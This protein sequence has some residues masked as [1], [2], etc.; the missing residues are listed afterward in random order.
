MDEEDAEDPDGGF[1]G[2][3]AG[4]DSARA[5]ALAKSDT[6]LTTFLRW[7]AKKNESDA[8]RAPGVPPPSTAPGH[9][10][11]TVLAS[12]YF[13]LI[14][15][16]H[17]HAE[18]LD[19]SSALAR[20][21]P[22]TFWDSLGRASDAP[23]FGGGQSYADKTYPRERDAEALRVEPYKRVARPLTDASLGFK[24]P[25][26]E[27]G[28]GASSS[29]SSSSFPSS[30]ALLGRDRVADSLG[31]CG[32]DPGSFPADGAAASA[33]LPLP[34]LW[35]AAQLLYHLG[36]S[37]HFKAAAY[38][39]QTQIQA[40]QQLEA[41]SSRL[42]KAEQ[43]A[44]DVA[45]STRAT[46]KSAVDEF[47]TRTTEALEERMNH[48]RDNDDEGEGG[49]GSDEASSA[50]AR[51]ARSA[52]EAEAARD[53]I[54]EANARLATASAEMRASTTP[55]NELLV[56]LRAARATLRDD[57]VE[58]ARLCWWQRA[59]LHR[60][61]Q[62]AG[63]FAVVAYGAALLLA[64]MDR[65]GKG[66]RKR[67]PGAEEKDPEEKDA[68]GDDARGDEA[69]SQE[70]ACSQ[71]EAR[72]EEDV[73]SEEEDDSDHSSDDS[74][75]P[76][77]NRGALLP[78]VSAYHLESLMDAFHALRRGDPPLSP[79]APEHLPGVHGVVTLLARHFADDRVANP[80]VRDAMLQSVSVLLQYPEYVAVFERNEEATRTMVP[81]LLRAF[82]SRF[83]IP[84]GNILLRLCKGAGFG[85][86][87]AADPIKAAADAAC[88][89][90]TGGAGVV[91]A[92]NSREARERGSKRRSAIGASPLF[93]RRIVDAC[94]SDP[95]LLAEFLDRLFNTLNWTITEL[96]VT[97]KEMLETRDR[98]RPHDARQLRRKCTV[99]FELSVTLERVLECFA[100][101]L[102]GAFL[103][104]D[105]SL[106]LGRLTESLVFVLGHTTVGPDATLFDRALT[107]RL[108]PV[109]KV[110]R[111]PILAPVAG[112]LLALDAAEARA[113]E[114]ALERDEESEGRPRTDDAL[115][116]DASDAS[117]SPMRRGPFRDSIASSLANSSCDVA[118]LEYLRD[119]PWWEH[120]SG[121]NE[122][123]A[124]LGDFA[125][126]VKSRREDVE[127]MRE[128]ED[129]RSVPDEFVDPIMQTVMTDPVT[130]PG[131][132]Q[133][134]DRATIK[135]HLMSDGTDPFSRSPLD[136]SMLVP[137]EALRERIEAWRREA[138][139]VESLADID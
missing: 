73:R 47:A 130:L 39:L 53:A 36:A 48:S 94:V 104:S 136:E 42:R 127:R 100:L 33:A 25:G 2:D 91:E 41:A 118:Q 75:D 123:L 28:S 64:A 37:A 51:S 103:N 71:E 8:R 18:R 29:S 61:D 35:D 76:E 89:A 107:S 134:V 16:L 120:F 3:P 92:A 116:D 112:I 108:A 30:L 19:P 131:S 79:T 72:S 126:R 50:A 135:R 101:E 102:P 67:D 109:D 46:M 13:A 132:G 59:A 97:L 128:T 111:A 27:E 6:A 84:V 105:A 65:R 115:S 23:L 82:D 31:A 20:P 10:D 74:E 85:Q 26:E 14:A 121:E 117:S 78:H 38:Q 5:R 34:R 125:R 45:E 52:A 66:R 83:W 122:N 21:P 40:A 106:D 81:A 55:A 58:A 98:V 96:G 88:D 95:K 137:A 119:F 32:M 56:K 57:V 93:R 133:T 138:P 11:P 43:A 113:V 44:R 124:R 62:R 9:S 77:K 54:V 68:R 22:E 17:P 60:P 99:M 90:Q 63:M 49:D 139:E 12:A 15:L 86:E 129:A 114:D 7:L 70:E 24:R 87:K 80:D 69:P 110:S 4:S 1:A